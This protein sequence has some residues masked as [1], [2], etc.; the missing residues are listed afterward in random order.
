MGNRRRII[1][2]MTSAYP[3]KKYGIKLSPG[4]CEIV[5]VKKGPVSGICRVCGCTDAFACNGGCHW[6]DAKHTICSRCV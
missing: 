3:V 4:S 1:K 6:M 2:T 5:T